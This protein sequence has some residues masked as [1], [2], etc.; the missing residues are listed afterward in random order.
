MGELFSNISTLDLIFAAV[1][2]YLITSLVLRFHKIR[3]ILKHKENLS[4]DYKL[5]DL[6]SVM[7]KCKEL[8]P[9]DTVYFH[10]KVFH[11]GMRVKI[12]TFQKK[13]IEGELIGKNKVD[14]VCVRTQNHII[15]HE[16]EK[17]ED[18]I[19]AEEP[20]QTV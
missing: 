7:T 19:V 6:A 10:G 11:R 15:A 14:L 12:T 20:S 8:F 18:M 2:A 4:V 13:V 5:M 3:N 17:I 1:L 16:I 9:I